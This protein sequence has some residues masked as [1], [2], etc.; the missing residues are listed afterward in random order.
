MRK[1]W[2]L[3]LALPLCATELGPRYVPNSTTTVTTDT[4]RLYNLHLANTTAGAVTVIIKD[5]STNCNSAACEL[6]PTV[7]IAADTV[8]TT[9]LQGLAANSGFTWEA[10]SANAVVG[11][12]TYY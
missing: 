6:W 5:R 4:V 7:S 11:W 12:I 10:S 3:L 2:I 9:N 1:L 8:Y